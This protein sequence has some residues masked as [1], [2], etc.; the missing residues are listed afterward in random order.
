MPEPDTRVR[1]TTRPAAFG[2]A[3]TVVSFAAPFRGGRLTIAYVPDRDLLTLENM[4]PYLRGIAASTSEAAVT[5]VAEDVANELVP[6]WYRVSFVVTVDAITHTVVVEDRQ[7][8][9]DHP[10]LLTALS[11]PGTA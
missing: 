9:W 5:A 8:G 7:P 10:T 4:A 6:R 1:L 2:T 11:P 3:P